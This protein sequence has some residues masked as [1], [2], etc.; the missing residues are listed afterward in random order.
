MFLADAIE[1]YRKPYP[2]LDL[3]RELAKT[4]L[5]AAIC[6]SARDTQTYVAARGLPLN[7][8]TAE[9]LEELTEKVQ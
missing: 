7:P 1:P 5:D 2:G 6:Q 8:H 4:D 9:M 3:I